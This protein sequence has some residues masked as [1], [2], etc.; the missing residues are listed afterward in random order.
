MGSQIGIFHP[1]R[2]FDFGIPKSTLSVATVDFGVTEIKIVAKYLKSVH[3]SEN[4]K[5][6]IYWTF[7]GILTGR[8]KIKRHEIAVRRQTP[9]K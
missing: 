6:R 8:I 5:P 4:E 2:S 7:S 9:Y 3:S 1:L